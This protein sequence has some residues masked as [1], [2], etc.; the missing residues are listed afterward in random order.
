MK[1][2]LI[3]AGIAG[4][5]GLFAVGFLAVL[6][7]ATAASDEQPLLGKREESVALLATVDDDDDDDTGSRDTGSRDTG[8]RDTGS[9]DTGSRDTGSRDTGSRDTGSRDTGSVSRETAAG[10]QSAVS[11][12]ASTSRGTRDWTA[13]GTDDRS[14]DD[15]RD[16][17]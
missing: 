3:R 13:T 9:R 6:P 10:L 14:R 8:S 5:S 11:R 2:T 17:R 7:G 1:D 12:D 16:R 4:F 15:S